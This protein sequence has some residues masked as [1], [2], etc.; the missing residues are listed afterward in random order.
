MRLSGRVRSLEQRAACPSVG[1]RSLIVDACERQRA[2]F[3]V[4]VPEDLCGAVLERLDGP[5]AEDSESYAS[6]SLWPFARWAQE[7]GPEY[8]FPRALV[9]W[10]LDPPRAFWMGH[11]CGRC[12]LSVPL[13]STHCGD[14]DPP[15]DLRVF[16]TCPAC[17]G[18]TSHAASYRPDPVALAHEVRP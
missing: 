15:K 11:H 7:P 13:Y 12:G 3:L 17:G 6:W 18:V 14:P 4:W 1:D 9:E 8:R 5:Y 10:I 16:P 2:A